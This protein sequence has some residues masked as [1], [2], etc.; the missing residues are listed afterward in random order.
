MRPTQHGCLAPDVRAMIETARLILR[1]Q[2]E[3]DLDWFFEHMNTPAV[4]RHLGGP[5]S[6]EAVAAGMVRN[7]ESFART[8]AGFWTIFLRESGELAGKCGLGTIAGEHAPPE[9][10]GQP[11]IGWSLAEPFWGRGLATEAAR[12]VLRYGFGTLGHVTIFSQTSTSNVASTRMMER[13]G[14][15]R[16]AELDYVDPDY[17]AA[18]NPTTVYGLTSDR[19][20]VPA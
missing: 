3:D 5:R 18:D 19:L 10:G 15:E 20:D 2:R 17:L 9:L 6:R 4:M 14:F 11:E 8:G 1:V 13:L 16:H 7:A 12:A